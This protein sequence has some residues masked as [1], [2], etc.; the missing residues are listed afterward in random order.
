MVRIEV[1]IDS[2][3]VIVRGQGNFYCA[4]EPLSIE[5]I[6]GV[7]RGVVWRRQVAPGF[8]DGRIQT[9]S[10]RVT[11]GSIVTCRAGGRRRRQS[12]CP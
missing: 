10:S 4:E 6:A 11:S 8:C 5:L 12:D 2:T 7:C 9:K 3:D 1:V